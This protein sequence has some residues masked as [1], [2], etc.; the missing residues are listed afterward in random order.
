MK[1]EIFN[2]DVCGLEGDVIIKKDIQVIFTTDQTEG[3]SI[4]PHLS[5]EKIDI[6]KSCLN[7]VVQGNYLWG[8]GAQGYNKYYF[9]EK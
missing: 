2:C 8:Y 1:K 9:K 4:E 7:K 6:C 3:R 5:M